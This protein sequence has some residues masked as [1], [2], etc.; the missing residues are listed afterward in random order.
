MTGVEII[1][2]ERQ[3]HFDV[4]GWT[5]EHDDQWTDGELADAAS[6]YAMPPQIF[7]GEGPIFIVPDQ[8]PWD[9]K[10]F[11]H[12]FHLG[13]KGRIQELAKAG[14]LVAAEI[15]RLQRLELKLND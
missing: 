12:T 1:A 13:T 2:A 9:E 8:W 14:A 15:D 10:W 11:K 4:E 7:P 5:E 6:S 3:R